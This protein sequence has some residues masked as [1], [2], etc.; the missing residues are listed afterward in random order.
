MNY[1]HYRSHSKPDYMAAAAFA[2]M[3]VEQGSGSLHLTQEKKN[4][5][6][7]LS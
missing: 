2:V 1:N 4:C 7:L 3:H 6:E 5:C